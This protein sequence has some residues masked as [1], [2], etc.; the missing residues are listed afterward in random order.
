MCCDHLCGKHC[1][2]L[3]LWSKCHARLLLRIPIHGL[4]TSLNS[5]ALEDDDRRAIGDKRAV[6]ASLNNCCEFASTKSARVTFKFCFHRC[7]HLP[8]WMR[9]VIFDAT[10]TTGSLSRITPVVFGDELFQTSLF[11]MCW[12]A[13]RL[14]REPTPLLANLPLILDCLIRPSQLNAVPHWKT[15]IVLPVYQS[16]DCRNCASGHHFCNEDNSSSIIPTFSATNV[17]AKVDLLK[18]HV[19]WNWEAPE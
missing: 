1:F 10:T 9:Y 17:E 19:K 7:P 3:I 12:K 2:Q 8:R 11:G 5:I 16:S 18:I 4:T 15:G 13:Y 6:W 14:S